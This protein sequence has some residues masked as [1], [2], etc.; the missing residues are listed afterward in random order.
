[1]LFITLTTVSQFLPRQ[2]WQRQQYINRIALQMQHSRE[3]LSSLVLADFGKATTSSLKTFPDPYFQMHNS[4][5]GSLQ[6]LLYRKSLDKTSQPSVFITARLIDLITTLTTT[7][8]K[9]VR[10]S[11]LWEAKPYQQDVT[12]CLYSSFIIHL[13]SCECQTVHSISS[14]LNYKPN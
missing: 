14:L 1:M 8:I 11:K 10:R 4:C 2:A 6:F 5:Y 12:V 9:P 3:L 13:V 7:W